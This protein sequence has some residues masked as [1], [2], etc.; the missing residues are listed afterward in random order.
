M[1]PVGIL[2]SHKVAKIALVGARI[3]LQK[4]QRDN[5]T[6]GLKSCA[7][8]TFGVPFIVK[9]P[10]T[11]GFFQKIAS[12]YHA[13]LMMLAW[14]LLKWK[15]ARKKHLERRYLPSLSVRDRQLDKT[16]W[17]LLTSPKIWAARLWK[18]RLFLQITVFLS[19]KSPL[20]FYH[21]NHCRKITKSTVT[22]E[23]K[24]KKLLERNKHLNERVR[25]Q[26][27]DSKWADDLDL[28]KIH[29][30]KKFFKIYKS[31]PSRFVPKCLQKFP[32]YFWIF[33]NYDTV[34]LWFKFVFF[35]I[36]TEIPVIMT[37]LLRPKIRL[38]VLLPLT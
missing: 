36:A 10:L 1:V 9:S 34:S 16:P 23:L 24:E 4:G 38:S 30:T 2:G 22:K 33:I 27:S 5:F 29:Q 14:G 7:T 26:S 13:N 28:N 3:H 21:P 8:Q 25:C 15:M 20:P 35:T 31:P 19:G 32:K 17:Q 18:L 37:E 6:R 12:T 11:P